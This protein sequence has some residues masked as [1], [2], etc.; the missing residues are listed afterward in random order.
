MGGKVINED[1]NHLGPLWEAVLDIYE[2]FCRVC[3]RHGL[4]HYVVSGTLLGA[5]RHKG[6]IPWD[7][8]FDLAMPRPDYEKL[9]AIFRNE[10][11]NHLKFMD[12]H[13]TPEFDGLFGKVMDVRRE[14][15]AEVENK[16]GFQLSN[17]L[18]IDIFPIDGF[19][20]RR[21]ASLVCR[22][23]GWL[24]QGVYRYKTRKNHPAAQTVGGKIWT[25]S[26]LFFCPIFWPLTGGLPVFLDRIERWLKRIPFNDGQPSGLAGCEVGRFHLIF[27]AGH[28]SNVESLPYEGIQ[29]VASSKG[30]EFLSAR[31]GDYMKLPPENKRKPTHE[32][33]VRCPWWLGPTGE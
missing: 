6:F 7:D 25:L 33:S 10:F 26:G 29:V 11:P 13:N 16:V 23:R 18:F 21:F 17:G 8:D 15:I 31:Y 24:Q 9:K 1:P 19:P 28:W 27:P 22:I 12:Q 14:R 30:R 3:E 20:T 2:E 4:R 5:I 32:L